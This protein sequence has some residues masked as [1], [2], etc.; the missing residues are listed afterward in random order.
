MQNS[1]KQQMVCPEGVGLRT[2][3]WGQFAQFIA[4]QLLVFSGH[5]FGTLSICFHLCT[6]ISQLK[7]LRNYVKKFMLCS[8]FKVKPRPPSLAENDT[9]LDGNQN[10]AGFFLL[11]ICR[12][13]LTLAW[14]QRP[15][16]CDLSF[17]LNFIFMYLITMWIKLLLL[18]FLF[19][20]NKKNSYFFVGFNI[21]WIT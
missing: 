17:P 7:I 18:I 8:S 10:E 16:T 1:S 21:T 4:N 2:Q 19:T 12:G 14:A 5:P 3:V 20:K 11:C 9:N 6:C 15:H 13:L